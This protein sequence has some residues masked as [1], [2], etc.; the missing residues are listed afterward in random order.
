MLNKLFYSFLSILFVSSYQIFA[1]ILT[2]PKATPSELGLLTLLMTVNAFLFLFVDFGFGNYLIHKKH[3]NKKG[4]KRLKIINL[5]ISIFIFFSAIVYSCVMYANDEDVI[6]ILA[7]LL[8]SI[9]GIFLSLSRIDRAMF[10]LG[11]DFKSIFKVDLYSR[12]AGILLLFLMVTFESNVVLSYLLST[13]VINIL[14]KVIIEIINYKKEIHYGDLDSSGLLSFCIPQFFNSVLNFS[15]QNIDLII[16]TIISGLEVGGV[17]GLIKIISNKPISL[18]MPTILKV[19]TPIISRTNELDVELRA[20]YKKV[21]PISFFTYLFILVFSPFILETFFNIDDE[22]SVVSLQMFSIYMYLRAISMPI[23]AIIVRTGEVL[24]GLYFSIFQVIALPILLFLIL[25]SDF[26]IL[27]LNLIFYQFVITLLLWF[28][29]VRGEC[30]TASIS[31]VVGVFT[32]LILLALAF[33]LSS[34]IL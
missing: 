3:L 14:A 9:N 19:Y 13:I 8:T 30:K 23:G 34:G 2:T 20:L 18:Y 27:I 33:Y 29:F 11:G 4:V 17:Y 7:I 32:P 22:N 15:T 16:I 21:I 25:P 5:Y 12:L 10:Q 6:F 31:E 24:K 26:Y 28:F 1:L